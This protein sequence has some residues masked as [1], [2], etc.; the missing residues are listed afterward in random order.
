MIFVAV[1]LTAL[2]IRAYANRRPDAASQTGVLVAN[3]VVVAFM[4][5]VAWFG[6]LFTGKIRLEWLTRWLGVARLDMN[7]FRVVLFT[8]PLA[9]AAAYLVIVK[10]RSSR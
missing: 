4:T 10:M 6:L 5:W 7:S 2:A 1:L 8:P 9:A 3:A